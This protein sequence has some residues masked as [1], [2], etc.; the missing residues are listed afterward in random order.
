MDSQ[1]EGEHEEERKDV[2][3]GDY[4]QGWSAARAEASDKVR[5]A[6]GGGRDEA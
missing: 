2:A 4:H 1:A 3:G 5:T 6:P